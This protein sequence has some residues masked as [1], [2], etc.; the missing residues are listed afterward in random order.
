[1]L[2]YLTTNYEKWLVYDGTNLND[3]LDGQSS[4][5]FNK[6]NPEYK[7]FT[8]P[9]LYGKEY[10]FKFPHYVVPKSEL[11]SSKSGWKNITLDWYEKVIELSNLGYINDYTLWAHKALTECF[12]IFVKST[13]GEELYTLSEKELAVAHKK[14]SE[15]ETDEEKREAT[16]EIYN[17]KHKTSDVDGQ[18]IMMKEDMMSYIRPDSLFFK[19]APTAKE[20][21]FKIGQDYHFKFEN[22]GL[23][24]D[25]KDN[26]TAALRYAMLNKALE[27]WNSNP[28]YRFHQRSTLNQWWQS[29]A[30][31]RM[32]R[33][34]VILAP[35]RAGKSFLLAQEIMKELLAHNYKKASRPRSVIFLSKDFDAVGQVMDYV[36]AITNDFDWLKKM[37]NYDATNH[38][39]SLQ[40]YDSQGKKQI[41]SQCKFYSA[42]WKLPA[43]GDAADAVIVDEALLIPE[44]IIDKIMPIVDN[45][46]ARLLVISTFY[47]EDEE[48]IDRIYTWP[49]KLCNE[50]EKESSKIIDIDE[51]IIKLWK[52]RERDG[53]FPD[54]CAGLR[55]TIDDV[56]VIINKEQVKKNLADK[57]ERYM[58]ELYC[59]TSEAKTVFNYKPYIAQVYFQNGPTPYYFTKMGT[60]ET[61]LTPKF[62]RIVIGYDPAQ[63]SDI[64]ALVACGYDEQR[65]KVV[66]MR[67][68]GLNYK[69]MSSYHPQAEEIKEALNDLS[70]FHCPIIKSM[71]NNHPG[72]VDV[73]A[74]QEH[75]LFFQYLY[76]W[77]PSK[78]PKKGRRPSEWIVSKETM[79]KAVQIMFDSKMVEIWSWECKGLIEQLDHFV[80]FKNEYTQRSKYKWEKSKHDDFVDAMM[81][82]LWTFWEH[83]GLKSKKLTID[84]ATERQMDI[85]QQQ[86]E[87][88]PYNMRWP[89]QPV[90]RYEWIENNFWY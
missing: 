22:Y 81:Y 86:N 19:P 74:G 66:V 33:K 68:W 90:I 84:V 46:L 43:V 82:C 28:K 20:N 10:K 16:E 61:I 57:P 3:V 79:V 89:I 78:D 69:D 1:M 8:I 26:Y 60:E 58:R 27:E 71:D 13:W 73:M 35:R 2:G 24:V 77:W 56:E 21:E 54:E 76:T 7:E 85:Q 42:L 12:D 83:Y 52:D 47:S 87:L 6:E 9:N 29:D 36:N 31:K 64:S 88:D 51:H 72:V 62:K 70:I 63:T 45:E 25:I 5:K 41:I 75:R 50:Y 11:A 40:T 18:L 59:R 67:E 39:L 49:V 44:R 80:E 38:I 30:S 15:A 32:A 17:I 4:L 34:T 37:L 55:Y 48:G 14:L 65:N 23:E 53:Y